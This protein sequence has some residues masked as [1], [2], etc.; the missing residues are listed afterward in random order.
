M[1]NPLSTTIR[2]IVFMA[3]VSGLA[4]FGKLKYQ[5][6]MGQ[7]AIYSTGLDVLALDE[8]LARCAKS[9]KPVRAIRV[10]NASGYHPIG[11]DRQFE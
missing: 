5:V 10:R 7:K 1:K 2:A 3:A 9:G 4:Y 8:A 11:L 6:Q